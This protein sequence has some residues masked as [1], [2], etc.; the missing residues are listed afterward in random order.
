MLT[1]EENERL[2]RVGPGT[3]MGNLQR[4]YWQPI[5]VVGE[6]ADRWTK[7][8]RLLGEDLVLYKDR[9]GKLGLVGE[10][11]PHRRA[12]L[13]YGIPTEAGIRCPYHGWQ[14]DGTGRCLEQ[15]NEPEGSAFRDKVTATAYPVETLAGIIFTYLGPQPAPLLPRWDGYVGNNTIRMMGW[16]IIPCNWL[17]CMENSVDPVHT[18]WLHGP[19]DQF[20][21]A[22]R[23]A[24]YEQFSRKHI[25]ID[26]VEFEYG[27]YKRRL[28][29][30]QSEDCEDW[31]VGHPVLIP[32]ILANGSGGGTLWK[33][34]AYQIRVPI[35]DENTLHYWF[36]GFE[37]PPG[38]DVP[39]RL[40]DHTVLYESKIYD[41]R[42][43]FNFENIENA[44]IMAWTSQG[45][46][47]DRSREAL[48]WADKGLTFYRNILKRE[49]KKVEAG[50]DPMGTFRD[51]AKNVCIT[52]PLEK[53][54]AHYSE[55][56]RSL[57]KRNHAG[58]SPILDEL[59]E[60][61]AEYSDAR[62]QERLQQAATV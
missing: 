4:R 35:D 61:F 60:I 59:C 46:I 38:V 33:Q 55:G 18:E 34:N 42:G 13:A 9:Q 49:L 51:P 50:A 53:N 20:Q 10:F 31:Q 43:E 52:F 11:C 17:Q 24:E 19:F 48:G 39:R 32:N 30:G 25:N 41:E 27:I 8:V 54:K 57:M 44:D 36:D 16:T 26:F 2:T 29:L 22:Q 6:M 62:L 21:A 14:F 5:G 47:F 1:V 37:P 3:P 56:F 15:P 58:S 7:R 28:L 12:S 23:K 45:R 40:L